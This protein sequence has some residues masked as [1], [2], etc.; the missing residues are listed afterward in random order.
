[1]RPNA[2]LNCNCDDVASGLKLLM[3][4]VL[5][6]T[7]FTKH[8]QY[9]WL[10]CW[11]QL[12]FLQISLFKINQLCIKY[13][14]EINNIAHHPVIIT[15][16]NNT[17]HLLSLFLWRF[18]HFHASLFIGFSTIPILLAFKVYLLCNAR[19]VTQAKWK[20]VA[21]FMSHADVVVVS[22]HF[23][24]GGF[25]LFQVSACQ[26]QGVSATQQELLKE[27]FRSTFGICT[28]YKVILPWKVCCW[29]ILVLNLESC[30][31]INRVLLWVWL[32]ALKVTETTLGRCNFITN[33]ANRN[34]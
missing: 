32:P 26:P 33:M 7:P 29:P 23:V 9:T 19:E 13:K 22:F 31:Y 18:S 3:E 24:C 15:Y 2:K 14:W 5:P 6:V 20:E 28:S 11:Q 27:V 4:S 25:G 1:M 8:L 34:D 17:F 16:G 21:L 10:S 12:T 30:I